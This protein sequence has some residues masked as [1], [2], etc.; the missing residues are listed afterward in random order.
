MRRALIA[1]PLLLLGTVA[2][3]AAGATGDPAVAALQAALAQRG[4]YQGSVD[5]LSSDATT[6]AVVELQKERGLVTDGI[7]GP[8]TRK[9]LGALGR[10][11]LG[12]RILRLDQRG[13]DVAALQ[14]LL[15]E[16]GF[17]CGTFDGTL[18]AHTLAA[19]MRFQRW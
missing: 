14:F 6:A 13:Q 15:A 1:L 17:P 18:G 4:L 10:H 12:S 16:H 9:A 3:P 7:V 8:K 19:L 5:G 11:R 2:A